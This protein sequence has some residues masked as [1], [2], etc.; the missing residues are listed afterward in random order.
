VNHWRAGLPAQ[1]QDAS[2]RQANDDESADE[3]TYR[4]QSTFA[5]RTGFAHLGHRLAGE[6]RGRYCTL[7]LN[8]RTSGSCAVLGGPAFFVLR[9]FGGSR[10]RRL[11]WET[12][13]NGRRAREPSPGSELAPWERVLSEQVLAW[14]PQPDWESSP[15][16]RWV[17][18][19]VD[20][21]ESRATS[22]IEQAGL[23]D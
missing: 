14:V 19:P 11:R 22:L 7:R 23:R 4:G 16:Y 6:I 3:H 20:E 2:N 21:H 9:D 10:R 5:G 12:C 15:E 17:P 8:G 1:L 18:S 13:L